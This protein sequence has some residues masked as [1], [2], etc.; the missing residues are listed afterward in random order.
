[1]KKLITQ[2][3]GDCY[4]LGKAF[5]NS[6]PNS[7]LHSPEFTILEFYK[8]GIDYNFI[9]KE[10]RRLLLFIANK[11]N[12]KDYINY[13][14]KKISLSMP[15]EEISITEAF[16]RFAN[17][18]KEVLFDHKLFLSKARQKG[19]KV[20]N[21]SYVDLFS[22]IYTQEVEL[23]LGINGR[24]TI[25]YDYPKE[26]AALAKMN[27]DGL[28]CQRFEFYIDG[29]ELGDCYT[30]LTNWQEQEK[31]LKA[32]QQIRLKQGKINHSVDWDFI[33]CL[34]KGLPD[35][36]GIAIG[37]DR[38]AMIFA[39]VDSINKLKLINIA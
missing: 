3:I 37:F 23:F 14:G 31:R 10:I 38:L 28:T 21:A 8:I 35:C 30:E 25:I 7:L 18:K 16:G 20:K 22:Q 26:M 27:K 5:R 15:W 9:K 2:G 39:N 33:T 19:Y 1:M 4:Y 6:E 11:V 12:G 17:I 13:K 36:S 32:E 29:V 24:P 34:K